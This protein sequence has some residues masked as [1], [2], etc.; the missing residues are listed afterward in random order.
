METRS[1][2]SA[3]RGDQG[4]SAVERCSTEVE[5]HGQPVWSGPSG[6]NKKQLT[7]MDNV[8]ELDTSASV[9]YSGI[10]NNLSLCST[11]AL[12]SWVCETESICRSRWP[13]SRNSR[14]VW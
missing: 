4:N 11:N 10:R 7:T 13:A 2:T 5:R 14:G 12:A 8:A 6:V 3:K 9:L 1:P